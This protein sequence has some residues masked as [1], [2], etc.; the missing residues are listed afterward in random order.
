MNEFIDYALY[1]SIKSFNRAFFQNM[2]EKFCAKD[3]IDFLALKSGFVLTNIGDG[4]QSIRDIFN[5]IP[6]GIMVF[7][8]EV[9]AS[10]TLKALGN[11]WETYSC[12]CIMGSVMDAFIWLTPAIQIIQLCK[13][14]G[15]KK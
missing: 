11:V 12:H 14:L 8:P 3:G 10:S 9:C 7:T 2:Q 13:V 1:G 15:L 4:V 6:D 5:N